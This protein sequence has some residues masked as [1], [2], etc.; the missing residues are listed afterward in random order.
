M[1]PPVRR[2]LRLLGYNLVPRRRF[3]PASLPG[4][5]IRKPR[6]HAIETPRAASPRTIAV[7]PWPA[8]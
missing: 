4:P 8:R 3:P 2:R 7:A 6:G 1:R 5:P